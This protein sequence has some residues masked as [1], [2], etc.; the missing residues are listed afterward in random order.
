MKVGKRKNEYKR[1]FISPRGLRNLQAWKAR[2]IVADPSVFRF[3]CR[4]HFFF[5]TRNVGIGY[6]FVL[7]IKPQQFPS[8]ELSSAEA[9]PR[10]IRR[11]SWK[12]CLNRHNSWQ[13]RWRKIILRGF[14]LNFLRCHAKNCVASQWQ[15]TRPEVSFLLPEQFWKIGSLLLPFSS[16]L[17]LWPITIKI[18]SIQ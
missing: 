9:V 14:V 10:D 6:T 15:M 3:L 2:K 18:W 13:T 12:K 5:S 16:R 1:I 17:S 11:K 7:I 4:R 8:D